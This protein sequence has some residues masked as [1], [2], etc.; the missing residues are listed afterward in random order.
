MRVSYDGERKAWIYIPT[1]YGPDLNGLC[2]DCN[3]VRDDYKTK[4]GTDVSNSKDK[5]ALIGNSYLTQVEGF[6]QAESE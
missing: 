6:P 5:Y 4:N 1:E 3:N 2:G